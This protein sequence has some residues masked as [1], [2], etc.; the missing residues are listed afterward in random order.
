MLPFILGVWRALYNTG[1][2][3][4]LPNLFFVSLLI[5]LIKR[6]H[7]RFPEGE[8]TPTCISPGFHGVTV[9]TQDSE[10]CDPSSNLGGTLVCLVSAIS[11]VQKVAGQQD[12]CNIDIDSQ[13]R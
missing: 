11:Q 13:H 1:M 4:A 5:Q 3:R 9:S 12:L 2:H 8:T 6:F 7:H 10:S